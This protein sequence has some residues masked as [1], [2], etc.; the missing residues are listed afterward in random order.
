[1]TEEVLEGVAIIGV[2]GRFPGAGSVEEFWA[3]LVA[4][5]ETVSFFSDDELI[6]AGLDPAVTHFP[7]QSCARYS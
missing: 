6:A 2:H 3:N 4:G 7:L 1:M 5:R